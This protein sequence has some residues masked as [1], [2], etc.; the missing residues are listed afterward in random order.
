MTPYKYTVD[1]TVLQIF[2]TATKAQRQKLL[3][4]FDGLAA[5]PFQVGDSI[6]LDHT[7]RPCQVK[8]FDDWMITYWPE[9][10]A[11]QIHILAAENLR[12]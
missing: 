7:G 10:L 6:Q 3:Q 2:A 11:C 8:R 5:H 12:R 4:V 9:H 1:R